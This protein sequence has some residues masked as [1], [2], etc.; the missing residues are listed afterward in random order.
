[1]HIESTLKLYE[2]SET[3]KPHRTYEAALRFA[4]VCFAERAVPP[5]QPLA[6]ANENPVGVSVWLCTG[7]S[8]GYAVHVK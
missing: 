5:T 7:C 1:M 4:S 6:T 2:A 3:S 8:G